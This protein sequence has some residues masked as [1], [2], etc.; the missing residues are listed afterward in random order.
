MA[1][2]YPKVFIEYIDGEGWRVSISI[3]TARDGS[4]FM[5]LQALHQTSALAASL[6]LIGQ[7]AGY[8]AH[9]RKYRAAVKE[10]RDAESR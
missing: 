9:P 3:P 7:V 5:H 2:E 10:A 6:H 1:S 4:T 8:L